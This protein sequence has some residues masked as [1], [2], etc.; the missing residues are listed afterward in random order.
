MSD[1]TVVSTGSLPGYN[2]T[3]GGEFAVTS[4]A[5]SGGTLYITSARGPNGITG[6]STDF[7]GTGAGGSNRYLSL[8][9]A[10]ADTGV[11]LTATPTGGAMGVAR[12]AGTSLA[13]LGEATSSNAKTDKAFFEFNLPD[14]YVAN[15]NIAVSVNAAVLGTGTLTAVSTTMTVAAYTETLGVETALTVSAAQ[16]MVAAGST[17][18]FT[19]TGTGLVPGQHLGLELVG[20]VTTASGA[21]TLEVNSVWYTA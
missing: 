5:V 8:T 19:V 17:L 15:A 20:L 18:V 1:P 11:S 21:N 16:Q 6:L 3:P 7:V 2:T 10:K 12:T 4:Q 9:N 14:S 13:L